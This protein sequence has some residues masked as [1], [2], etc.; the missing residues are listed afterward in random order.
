MS[1]ELETRL[2]LLL[3]IGR[4]LEGTNKIID[5]P[6]PNREAHD[7]LKYL[8]R[9]NLIDVVGS[10]YSAGDESGDTAAV[11]MSGFGIFRIF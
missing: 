7:A 3:K 4:L 11:R 9:N 2:H 5:V 10:G 8:N 6:M 1:D